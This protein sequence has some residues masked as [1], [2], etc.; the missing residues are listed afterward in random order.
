LRPGRC[1]WRDFGAAFPHGDIKLAE[2]AVDAIVM[3]A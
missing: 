1:W 2:Y 3:T